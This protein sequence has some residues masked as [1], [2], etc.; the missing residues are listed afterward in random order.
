MGDR[1]ICILGVDVL[2][3]DYNI[4]YHLIDNMHVYEQYIFL[5]DDDERLS[6]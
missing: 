6:K 2:L 5:Q 1:S 4:L 3:R